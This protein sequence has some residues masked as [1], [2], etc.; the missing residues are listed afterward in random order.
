MDNTPSILLTIDYEPWF[1]LTRRYD[2]L[3][4][5]AERKSLDDGFSLTALDPILSELA[6]KQVSFYLVGEIADWYPEVPRRIVEAGH[7]LGLHCQYHRPLI[8][9]KDL[10]EDLVASASWR[11]RYNVTGY[12]AP[13]VGISEAGYSAL[14][15]HGIAY[16]SSIYAPSGNMLRKQGVIEL[17]VSSLNL[18]GKKTQLNAPRQFD[19]KLLAQ[20]EVPFGSSFMIGLTPALILKR[21]ET[22]LAAGLSPVIILHPYELFPPEKFFAKMLPDLLGNPQLLPFMINK[23]PFLRSLLRNFPVQPMD[24]YVRLKAGHPG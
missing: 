6:G 15:E 14:A 4:G 11:K 13:M 9:S 17:P 10:E 12:R 5:Q 1:A 7:E 23:L 3:T 24:R 2:S 20:G 19:T 21:L 18:F 22:E 8:D 16:S